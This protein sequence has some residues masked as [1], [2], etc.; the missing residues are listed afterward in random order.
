MFFQGFL[1]TTGN[2]NTVPVI[3]LIG[4]GVGSLFW[5]AS[6]LILGWAYAR[7]GW[8]GIAPEPPSNPTVNYIGVG[9]GIISTI[10][11]AFLKPSVEPI[12]ERRQ[13]TED[14]DETLVNINNSE[15]PNSATSIF[16]R[17]SKRNKQ[18]LGSFLSLFA[19]VM[20][21][22]A[23]APSLHIQ[24]K[25]PGASQNNL[26]YA[27]SMNTGIF[28]GSLFYFVV[29]CVAKKNKPDVYPQVSRIVA[30]HR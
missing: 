29:Y 2:I 10:A 28:L 6:G 30:N 23:Y 22:L 27:F 7:F 11:L 19:G 25:Y 12:A 4:I 14:E 13:L 5:N 18:I 24:S 17:M 8:F 15:T 20:Y 3:K 16:D 1:W 21:A 9:I 26:D